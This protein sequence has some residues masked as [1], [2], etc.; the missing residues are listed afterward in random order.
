[1]YGEPTI[2]GARPEDFG[3]IVVATA[4]AFGDEGDRWPEE[5]VAKDPNH[6]PELHR[7]CEVDGKIVSAMR[8]VCQDV[9]YGRA[10]LKHTGVGDVGTP[11]EYRRRGYSTLVLR[12][13]IAHMESLG[14]HF[15]ILYTGIQPFY[16]RLGWAILPAYEDRFDLTNAAT[17]ASSQWNGEMLAFDPAQHLDGYRELYEQFNATRSG[18]TVREDRYWELRFAEGPR[19]DVLVA[20]ADGEVQA[21]AVYEVHEKQSTL[22]LYEYAGRAG[23]EDALE[24]LLRELIRRGQGAGVQTLVADFSTDAVALWAAARL[25]EPMQPREVTH[26]MFRVID[27]CGLL[28]AA[29]P[30]LSCR[31]AP[32]AEQADGARLR[33]TWE[34]QTAVL[35]LDDGEL[36][37]TDSSE[38]ARAELDLSSEEIVRLIFGEG[39]PV[40][41][42]MPRQAHLLLQALFP[43][44]DLVVWDTDSF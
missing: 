3:E 2:R 35:A 11:P 20:V 17:E 22:R 4:I 14:S 34:A 39:A 27:L 1:M 13:A 44:E 18:T 8:I 28:R 43:G 21:S 42:T 9:R 6:R 31:A 16:E 30:E 37:V 12:D 41:P 24:A 29:L 5:H 19:D 36:T 7:V 32:V 38:N 26:V 15:S 23:A 25:A 10:V 40:L 33:L